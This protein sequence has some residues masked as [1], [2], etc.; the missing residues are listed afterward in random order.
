MNEVTTSNVAAG[1][2]AVTISVGSSIGTAESLY[3]A[4]LDQVI[5]GDFTFVMSDAFGLFSMLLLALN[6]FWTV[7]KKRRETQ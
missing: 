1:T 4:T 6:F 3:K 2:T 5:S 7:R